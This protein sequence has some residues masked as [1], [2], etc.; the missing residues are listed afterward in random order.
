MKEIKNLVNG[1][2][3]SSI[4]TWEKTSPFD[5]RV[6]ARVHEADKALVDEAIAAGRKEAFGA[7]GNMA[8][9][10]RVAIVRNMAQRL[11]ARVDDLIEADMADTGRPYW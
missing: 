8:M 6:V 9:P 2:W 11:S 3:H 5:G 1:S 4:K 10:Q 7:W